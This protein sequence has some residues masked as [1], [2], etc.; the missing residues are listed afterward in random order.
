MSD[1]GV[2]ITFEHCNNARADVAS[3]SPSPAASSYPPT[4]T[5]QLPGYQLD[6]SDA[7]EDSWNLIPYDVPWGPDYYHY[8]PGTLPGPDGACIFLRSPTPLRNKRTQRACNKC[9]QRKAKCSGGRPTCN[10]CLA[11]GYVCEYDDE[12][13]KPLVQSS[14]TSFPSTQRDPSESS[15]ETEVSS[16]EADYHPPAE[17]YPFAT[18]PLKIEELDM[19]PNLHYFDGHA[20]PKTVRR[21]PEFH[22]TWADAQ[23]KQGAQCQHNNPPESLQDVAGHMVYYDPPS[24]PIDTDMHAYQHCDMPP[25][26]DNHA[27][28]PAAVH[29]PRPLRC[30][31]SPSFLAPEEPSAHFSPCTMQVSPHDDMLN[32]FAPVAEPTP[33]IALPHVPPMPSANLV[34]VYDGAF[35]YGYPQPLYY[36]PAGP[37]PQ[38]PALHYQYNTST[39]MPDSVDAT[40]YYSMVATGMAS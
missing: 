40:M 19:T 23:Y 22:S 26:Y 28:H 38:H 39:Y 9:R 7:S 36:G 21:E 16:P 4:P 12:D 10:R 37:T 17:P 20:S 30:V 8:K 34:A 32:N 14:R 1:T 27:S 24:Y 25:T 35:Q 6:V 29:A 3:G 18:A 33:H 5:E 31:G 15:D 2:T 11:R 13:E